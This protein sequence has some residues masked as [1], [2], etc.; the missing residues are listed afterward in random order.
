MIGSHFPEVSDKLLN[1]LQLNTASTQSELL[2]ASINQ[3]SEELRP[4][5]FKLAIN[6]KKNLKYLKYTAIP[7]LII[8]SV[9]LSG[10]SAWF[11]ESYQRVVN[12]QTAY[13]PPAPFQFFV[14]NEE[15]EVVENTS[16][17]L[18]IK[19]AGKVIPE[20]VQIKFNDETYY[21]QQQGLGSFE[22]VFEQ[23]KD[24]LTF[25][26]SANNVYSKPYK[27]RVIQAPT[28][29]SFDMVLNYP[30][31]TNK[32]DEILKSTGNAVVPAGTLATWKLRTKATD[33]VH[34]QAKDT[35]AFTN[36]GNGDF[37]SSKRLFTN[38][39]YSIATSNQ[40]LQGY[41]NAG[42]N[43]SVVRDEYPN[44]NWNLK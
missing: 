20:A 1:V 43:I 26:L 17:R 6:F 21:L 32:R 30:N 31:Y 15:L 23:L 27:I 41:E 7:I 9:V 33:H 2:L 10:K 13:E 24:N 28:L 18:I 14:L 4:I 34:L 37:V 8:A 36:E 25:R 11:S 22:Y 39:V 5:P 12:Y 19:T 35:I 3:K 38:Y 42:F 44:L 16:F 40:N 29:L